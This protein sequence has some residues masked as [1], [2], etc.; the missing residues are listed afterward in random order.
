MLQNELKSI[1]AIAETA[2]DGK[3]IHKLIVI[4]F[5]SNTKHTQAVRSI[6]ICV[7]VSLF[8]FHIFRILFASF[9]V[10]VVVVVFILI[11]V[12]ITF[13][14]ESFHLHMGVML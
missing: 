12:V 13:Q 2:E 8:T 9:F 3:Y 1:E 14:C 10:V 5:R 4:E 7:A 11:L 6:H